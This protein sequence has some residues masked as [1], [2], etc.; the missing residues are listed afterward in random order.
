MT[1][2]QLNAESDK[3]ANA[4]PIAVES[5]ASPSPRLVV[6]AD[7]KELIDVKAKLAWRR[8]VEGMIWFGMTC[9]G[10]AKTF[11]MIEAQALVAAEG[12]ATG[13]RWRLPHIP[14]LKTL[15]NKAHVGRGAMVDAALL[16]GTPAN[17]HWSASVSVGAGGAVN[18]YNYGNIMAGVTPTNA[19]QLKAL[20]G[21]GFNFATGEASG[22]IS[23][24]DALYVRLVR[25]HF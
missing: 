11:T 14:E 9:T 13:Q 20:E 23:K 8:C 25:P 4:S 6:S 5:V 7:G 15:L 12:K 10:R 17:W 21:W 1:A 22:G 3:P 24:R 19:N 18:Q 2:T 16:P